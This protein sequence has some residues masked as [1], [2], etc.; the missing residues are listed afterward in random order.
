MPAVALHSN[1]DSLARSFRIT[2]RGQCWELVRDNPRLPSRRVVTNHFQTDLLQ[3]VFIAEAKGA[4]CVI[5]GSGAVPLFRLLVVMGAF[6]SRRGVNDPLP[7]GL[8]LSD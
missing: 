7:R 5:L 8:V 4:I 1:V 2:I 6:A 3:H